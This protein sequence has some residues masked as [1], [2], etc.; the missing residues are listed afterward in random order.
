[1][2]GLNLE[3]KKNKRFKQVISF[4]LAF[5]MVLGYVPLDT[6]N[7]IMVNA[8]SVKDTLPTVTA[9]KS[10]AVI[11]NIDVVLDTDGN[12]WGNGSINPA[13]IGGAD[14]GSPLRRVRGITKPIAD[15][16]DAAGY[17]IASS[18][19][20]KTLYVLAQTNPGL[21][22]TASPENSKLY[23]YEFY[24]QKG[25]YIE[26]IAA[27]ATSW[28]NTNNNAGYVVDSAGDIWTFGYSGATYRG[29]SGTALNKITKFFF[30]N[31]LP[32]A[33][34]SKTG[35]F[36]QIA[37]DSSGYT[38]PGI[39][40]TTDTGEVFI[41]G[42]AV[43]YL[44]YGATD[45]KGTAFAAGIPVK[46]DTSEI[47]KVEPVNGETFVKIDSGNGAML[48]TKEGN[49][50]FVG[51]NANTGSNPNF[52]AGLGR[53]YTIHDGTT[54]YGQTATTTRA[55]DVYNAFI[56]KPIQLK[57]G[58]SAINDTGADPLTPTAGLI[59]SLKIV[60]MSYAYATL[61]VVDDKGDVYATGQNYANLFKADNVSYSYLA[62][63]R[64]GLNNKT[65][66]ATN[67]SGNVASVH[68]TP[69][70]TSYVTKNGKVYYT[71]QNGTYKATA[72][73]VETGR[74]DFYTE[75]PLFKGSNLTGSSTK[76][77]T[78][79]SSVL[80]NT[81]NAYSEPGAEKSNVTYSNK[82]QV[83]MAGSKTI[84]NDATSGYKP[85]GVLAMADNAS[86]S[87]AAKTLGTMRYAVITPNSTGK[88]NGTSYYDLALNSLDKTML[89]NYLSAKGTNSPVA[90]T[91]N[92]FETMYTDAT[93]LEKGNMNWKSG[94]GT[95]DS[96]WET[97]GN[98]TSNSIVVVM[99]SKW[100]GTV[101]YTNVMAFPVDNFYKQTKSYY[102]G[103]AVTNEFAG[104]LNL[105][106]N[107]VIPGNYGVF[108][109][110]YNNT[111]F[112]D[113]V[114]GPS[115][116]GTG[117]YSPPNGVDKTTD[118]TNYPSTGLTTYL[119][120]P[121]V[122]P[123]L[124][125]WKLFS[126]GTPITLDLSKSKG[127]T[128]SDYTT[129]TVD[130]K[131]TYTYEKE[132]SKWK[133]ATVHY[134]YYDATIPTPA[135]VDFPTSRFNLTEPN[136]LKPGTNTKFWPI[137]ATDETYS[138]GG[139]AFTPATV[140]T[141]D[142]LVTKETDYKLVGY[143]IGSAPANGNDYIPCSF[144]YDPMTSEFAFNPVVPSGA[145]DV[146][147]V[148][149]TDLL[150]VK[151]AYAD[152]DEFAKANTDP[153]TWSAK[154]GSTASVQSATTFRE[155]TTTQTQIVE[156]K[157]EGTSSA[158]VT[159]PQTVTTQ[160]TA[161]V[162]IESRT[163][164]TDSGL[165]TDIN[166]VDGA[167]KGDSSSP[168]S[169][170]T[171][172]TRA[173]AF[174]VS[175]GKA[176]YS[177]PITSIQGKMLVG[178]FR[179]DTD[180]S[181]AKNGSSELVSFWDATTE[182]FKVPNS[183]VTN[184]LSSDDE[185][186]LVYL[187][188]ANY[189][190]IP[191]VY[192]GYVEEKW[193]AITASG[194]EVL[195]NR[196][197]SIGY[198]DLTQKYMSKEES[199]VPGPQWLYKET[200]IATG[201]VEGAAT[202]DKVV[203]GL[204]YET[205]PIYNNGE[206]VYTGTPDFQTVTY[207]YDE[208]SNK[209]L[210][211]DKLEPVKVTVKG[212]DLQGKELYSYPLESSVSDAAF[213]I[214]AM[215]V[216]TYAPTKIE[217]NTSAS[218]TGVVDITTNAPSQVTVV[219]S[220]IN[221]DATEEDRNLV[222]TFVYKE[223]LANLT[224][225]Q[226]MTGS[227]TAIA[228][229]TTTVDYSKLY[230]APVPVLKGY[231]FDKEK[232]TTS[233]ANYAPSYGNGKLSFTVKPDGTSE[234]H[235][236]Y[237]KDVGN[238]V[239]Y[240]VDKAT[241]GEPILIGSTTNRVIGSTA[242]NNTYNPTAAGAAPEIFEI[243]LLGNYALVG[244]TGTPSFDITGTTPAT[245]QTYDGTTA[246]KAVYFFYERTNGAITAQAFMQDGTTPIL[247]ADGSA[248]ATFYDSEVGQTEV[249]TAPVDG[250]LRDFVL[251][252]YIDPDSG[253]LVTGGTAKSV[254]MA[255][256]DQRTEIKFIYRPL[257]KVKVKNVSYSD[258]NNNG[259]YDTGDYLISER[260]LNMLEGETVVLVA[261]DILT[262]TYKD[263]YTHDTNGVVLKTT[264]TKTITIDSNSDKVVYFRYVPNTVKI[265]IKAIASHGPNGVSADISSLI[266]EGQETVTA[267]VGASYT[268]YAP[269]VKGYVLATG[270]TAS[271]TVPVV[272]ATMA[273]ATPFVFTYI[274]IEDVAANYMATVTITGYN[275][276]DNK[277]LYKYDVLVTK[278]KEYTANAIQL[279]TYK[280][281][282]G[283]NVAVD[284]YSQK[285]TVPYTQSTGK[286]DFYYQSQ[287][288]KVHAYYWNDETNEFIDPSKEVKGGIK[289]SPITDNAAY[290]DGY[291]YTGYSLTKPSANSSP[292]NLNPLARIDNV[293]IG[294]QAIYYYYKP[295]GNNNVKI[296][297]LENDGTYK[298]GDTDAQK[299]AAAQALANKSLAS[300][301]GGIFG[302]SA[303]TVTVANTSANPVVIT[304][305]DYTSI[306]YQ[307]IDYIDDGAIKNDSQV[308]YESSKTTHN[309]YV[310]Y[311]KELADIKIVGDMYNATGTVLEEAGREINILKN[312]RTAEAIVIEPPYV[313]GYAIKSNSE[314]FN[315]KTGGIGNTITFKYWKLPQQSVTVVAKEKTTGKVISSYTV[316]GDIGTPVY[317][318]P[319]KLIGWKLADTTDETTNTTHVIKDTAETIYYE[320]VKD[321]ATLKA[322]YFYQA[323]DGTKTSIND[324]VDDMYESYETPNSN[325]E[326]GYS[327]NYTIYAPHIN[328]YILKTTANNTFT[329]TESNKT[330]TAEFVY[331]KIEDVAKDYMTNVNVSHMVAVSDGADGFKQDPNTPEPMLSYQMY[332][333]RNEDVDIRY[334][335]FEGY[336]LVNADGSAV[337]EEDYVRTINVNATSTDVETTVQFLYVSTVGEIEVV[338][339]DKDSNMISGDK[340]KSYFKYDSTV[341][342][343]YSTNATYVNDYNYL[344]YAI[345]NMEDTPDYDQAVKDGV[346][347]KDKIVT[348][349]KIDQVKA[350]GHKVCFFY[351]P[352]GEYA[353]IHYIE[354]FDKN[355]DGTIAKDEYRTIVAVDGGIPIDGFVYKY[356]SDLTSIS[357]RNLKDLLDADYYEFDD[358]YYAGTA[359][360]SNGVK[361][362]KYTYDYANMYGTRQDFYFV[363]KKEV[364][365]VDVEVSYKNVDTGIIETVTE[366]VEARLGEY[367]TFV[368]PTVENY[369]NVKKTAGAFVTTS[370]T[371]VNTYAIRKA[372]SD[373]TI[374][375]V[376]IDNPSNVFDSAIVT[377][378]S[379]A[380]AIVWPTNKIGWK[381][382]VNGVPVDDATTVTNADDAIKIRGG[383]SG[384][385]QTFSY[386]KNVSS[387][388][389]EYKYRNNAGTLEDIYVDG[390]LISDTEG[391]TPNTDDTLGYKLSEIV[392][393][394]QIPGY[395]LIESPE[396]PAVKEFKDKDLSANNLVHVFEYRKI[397]DVLK[398]YTVKVN[399]K[400]I[401]TDK[402]TAGTKVLFEYTLTYPE[403][404]T[405]DLTDTDNIIT[406]PT[407]PDRYVLEGIDVANEKNAYV[408]FTDYVK[409]VTDT[410]NTVNL[411]K[412]KDSEQGDINITFNYDYAPLGEG[413]LTIIAV[414]NATVGTGNVVLSR[415]KFKANL[416]SQL[417]GVAPEI[418]GYKL[419]E[420]Q[421]D[422]KS[423]M[424]REE[425]QNPIVTFYYD[426]LP[427]G[428][429][430]V[431]YTAGGQTINTEQITG[432]SAAGNS[433]Y[434]LP[435]TYV[436]NNRIYNRTGNQ[437]LTFAD[438][439][440]WNGTNVGTYVG[441]YVD[442]GPAYVE[443]I[444]TN[445][446]YSE[447]P[448]RTVYV[449]KIVY[450]DRPV[451][452]T[453]EYQPVDSGALYVGETVRYASGYPDNTFKP[454]NS[455]TRAEVAVMFY[456][457][458]T[459]PNKTK[460]IDGD[461]TDVDENQWYSQAV[462][463]LAKGG[464]LNGY[465]NGEFRP[466]A[467]I[468]RAEF[469]A[470][471]SRFDDLVTGVDATFTDVSRDHWAKDAIDSGYARGWINGY[472][473]GEF[474]PN[475]KITRAETVKIINCMVDRSGKTGYT[476]ADNKFSD[477][478]PSHW[479]FQ[480]IIESSTDYSIH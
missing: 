69:W 394:K 252:G 322:T 160:T 242:P 260:E 162:P 186:K 92:I 156:Q 149:K 107:K 208:D 12:L 154:T 197:F 4:V 328:G 22:V 377:V 340:V 257:D 185:I 6:F 127:K 205:K 40:A 28:G 184:N 204:A 264:T 172:Y 7:R 152:G 335:Y 450:V 478:T 203:S 256:A 9:K 320:Y 199:Y 253:N 41:W 106:N 239:L 116:I 133:P 79:G 124:N 457:L 221:K 148:Y 31:T 91:D 129:N 147:L 415:N 471:S 48:L 171:Y 476:Q 29:G 408:E 456:N 214:S 170:D 324:K 82:L 438:S 263:G 85:G 75:L 360:Y 26:D 344:G 56:M 285:V 61:L 19:D 58:Y 296:F 73:T 137:T 412:V 123:V 311:R 100:S 254:Y 467:T 459:D 150:V 226:F 13:S 295:L 293:D 163:I 115:Y 315:V 198:K 250:A 472:P 64:P 425:N 71:S 405:F 351:E 176:E 76:P 380:D 267:N 219:P 218:A 460:V 164:V 404:K 57:D 46:V 178:Y 470:I 416:G 94:F 291:Y 398:D 134:G 283:S 303:T 223:T 447:G 191:D 463:Y 465:G 275:Y 151:E 345:Y 84:S 14:A 36:V 266:F 169:L 126:A 419:T 304:K 244:G 318:K 384:L 292:S 96:L 2:E 307:V 222:I 435:A 352:A 411:L 414:D 68:C 122:S 233:D 180:S 138:V 201:G 110:E 433:N 323:K 189:N 265:P 11:D 44:I 102:N 118:L 119:T 5:A 382:V 33:E 143:K 192:E 224:V 74:W 131:V 298:T 8:Q 271:K 190:N 238:I 396:N 308:I 268:A 278:N 347:D 399:V 353:T 27:L 112:K 87:V 427:T 305:P 209:N 312:Q 108:V 234:M 364:Q 86:P 39:V 175:G 339:Y 93:V 125:Y 140:Y 258:T 142:S 462:N 153:S 167:P 59:D 177:K 392:Y 10:A 407:V 422:T 424:L 319:S 327:L 217:L 104:V 393:S 15:F 357:G 448:V 334:G 25:T 20:K 321:V 139:D 99:A 196:Q 338:H 60:D 468:T 413:W 88:Y 290:L 161:F 439:S 113:G 316:T 366:Q 231:T 301:N 309:V 135:F 297:Y 474:K 227:S 157:T 442:A 37:A 432:I 165:F 17:I 72:D 313:P 350:S 403:F 325:A 136:V 429:A 117:V 16:D 215:Q 24:D 294:N 235:V 109:D 211:V 212:V 355:H 216:P 426:A 183:I 383:V 98:V 45:S 81:T 289:G 466:T 262:Y 18:T 274:P 288:I 243:P 280:V 397:T 66:Q 83:T 105:Y 42:A 284:S 458:S 270:A 114:D 53:Y 410:D 141:D 287:E 430:T 375:Y 343:P 145:D 372:A 418:K 276:E 247:K 381:Y 269:N 389:V 200:R 241:L 342:A 1:M 245:T 277:P 103:T 67:L 97:S 332:V 220:A 248:V 455:I 421:S 310:V 395:V 306:G 146:Y 159:V 144:V 475:G 34:R 374:N 207:Y 52:S 330:T 300:K 370:T 54:V 179:E 21:G 77:V 63:I 47:A 385:T 230:Q 70:T 371:S 206:Y 317:L 373:F 362:P 367:S 30:P 55:V 409:V 336:K 388:K 406:A 445:T 354:Y 181:G 359:V 158:A 479:A 434:I 346:I 376:D 120:S 282:D 331:I 255:S 193:I 333:P 443:K 444:V 225:K 473:S 232:T 379:G 390:V 361:D 90:I 417:I 314:S 437:Q 50:F 337:D 32:V 228:T 378:L 272:D 281:L 95:T 273:T 236:Y 302:T 387:Y 461:F 38:E 341:D 121:T 386:K 132:G 246:L 78:G 174:A 35:K 451:Q 402:S 400:G 329:F 279:P 251:V 195:M 365:T 202:A 428:T 441:T 23:T 210:I 62:K 464:V 369:S 89:P 187:T 391:E 356:D 436:V 452:A 249:V 188:D 423:G 237:T 286:I 349:A 261:P 49:L 480:D 128:I 420:G 368:F 173:A 155:V 166:R 213:D 299:L 453:R 194:S 431:L 449:D 65:N 51:K 101:N 363:M 43:N 130:N 358:E 477:V 80:N 111:I 326:L 454:N 240:A 446:E 401:G 168:Y 229:Y 348:T 469:A 259:K 440:Q 3:Y 182:T